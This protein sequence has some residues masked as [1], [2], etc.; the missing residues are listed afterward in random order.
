ME[1]NKKK[2]I[3]VG[4]GFAG[5]TIARTLA[6]E[7][8]KV[9]VYE[10]REHLGGN[11]YDFVD[12]SG[13]YIHKYGPH[14][15]HTNLDNVYDYLSRFTKW[16]KY[17]HKVLGYIDDKF[18]PI[19]FSLKSL[20]MCFNKTQSEVIKNKLIDKFGEGKIT[21]T[22]LRKENDSEL[23]LL[24]DYVYNKVFLNYTKKQWGLLPEQLGESVTGRVPVYISYDERYFQDKYQCMPLEGYT[25]LF[26][27][28]L[29]HK[30]IE[31][32]L[33]SDIL[34]N[35]KFVNDEIKVEGNEDC[36]FIYTGCIDELFNY[37]FGELQY[38]SLNF[39]FE[40]LDIEN[41]QKSAVVNYPNTEKFTRITE[42]KKFTVKEASS[43]KT[44]IV[45]EYPCKYEDGL[46]P[47][48]PIPLEECEQQ[49]LKY[50]NYA[51]KYTNLYLIGRLAEYKYYNMDLVVNS[52]LEL[53]QKIIGGK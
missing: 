37:K 16:F 27:N 50:A 43:K 29:N 4:A 22:Q 1:K 14:I 41:F 6:D 34:K 52:A 8:Y 24:A 3:I 32:N 26:E 2:V 28:M 18:V 36:I 30:N 49:Y 13:A 12:E 7:G 42:F 20:E 51:K 19:P 47:Y 31:V 25:K 23:S 15:F 35:I 17:E 39:D 48:Y 21:I 9:E 40:T 11:A 45:K 10:R 5:A 46:I 38:R 33:N 53:A 44:T